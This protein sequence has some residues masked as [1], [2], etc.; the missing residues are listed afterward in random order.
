MACVSLL[1][2]FDVCLINLHSKCREW[3]P[4]SQCQCTRLALAFAM[5]LTVQAH[6]W[7]IKIFS[8]SLRHVSFDHLLRS[9]CE[10]RAKYMLPLVIQIL[11][12]R[13][14]ND[15]MSVT[16]KIWFDLLDCL[17]V[18]SW[19]LLS[20]SLLEIGIIFAVLSEL[21]SFLNEKIR[22][23]FGSC[24]IYKLLICDRIRSLSS[25]LWR[26]VRPSSEI[27]STGNGKV[28]G[29]ADGLPA[30]VIVS[31]PSLS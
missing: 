6:L 8:A 28:A 22:S 7:H 27:S 5:A 18:N 9:K 24:M 14:L 26:T 15:T 11:S 13:P 1:L 21:D 23:I 3:L 17:P 19:K 20:H 10:S 12:L 25:A 31:Q 4:C 29:I 30:K 2:S 16:V